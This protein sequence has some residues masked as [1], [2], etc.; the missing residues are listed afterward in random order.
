MT[1]AAYSLSAVLAYL[2][3][4]VPFG[5]IVARANGVDIRSVGSGNTGATNVWRSVGKGP[6]LVTFLCDALKGFV[7]AFCFPLIAGHFVEQAPSALGAVC[8]CMAVAGHNWPV[9]LRFKGGKGIATTIGALLGIAPASV[10]VMLVVWILLFAITRYVS[11]GS[12]GGAVALA[13]SS[14]FFYL[15]RGLAVPIALTTLGV[16]AIWRHRSNIRRLMQGTEKGFR[17]EK[18]TGEDHGSER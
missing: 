8:A 12:I 7:P 11:V 1:V 5:Y 14:W 3:G 13:A 18:N 10:G 9:F 6:G 17:R 15:D 4:A 16:V 2:L